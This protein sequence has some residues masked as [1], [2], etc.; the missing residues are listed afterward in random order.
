MIGTYQLL[1][2]I[3]VEILGLID[4]DVQEDF[5]INDY[6]LES[7]TFIEF[8]TAIESELDVELPDDFLD[9]DIL[10]SARGFAEKIDSY[11]ASVR[12]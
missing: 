7:L 10:I 2:K 1:I 3:L 12:G 6:I 11:L 9:Y 8:I 4:L 5:S